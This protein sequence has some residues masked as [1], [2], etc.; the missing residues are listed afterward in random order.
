MEDVWCHIIVRQDR[1]VAREL[2]LLDLFDDQANSRDLGV[3]EDATQALC[4]A[5]LD[6]CRIQDGHKFNTKPGY[7]STKHP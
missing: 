2:E 3:G 1:C 4:G 7:N 5:Y 6:R